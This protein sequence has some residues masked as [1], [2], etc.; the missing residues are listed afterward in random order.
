VFAQ[1]LLNTRRLAAQRRYGVQPAPQ[2]A[3]RPIDAFTRLSNCR[4][5]KAQ[6]DIAFSR[7][8]IPAIGR[9]Y[10]AYIEC[11]GALGRS[12]VIGALDLV[13]GLFGGNKGCMC[14]GRS[15][16]LHNVPFRLFVR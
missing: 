3:I 2:L 1:L 4:L 16:I 13:A 12:F 5:S 15:L 8:R 6:A 11:L 14:L 7:N 9:L 10:I